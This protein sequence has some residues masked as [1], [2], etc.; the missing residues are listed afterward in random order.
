MLKL[1]AIALHI[2]IVGCS[3]APSRSP[4]SAQNSEGVRFYSGL[5]S[6]PGSPERKASGQMLQE[7]LDQTATSAS[8]LAEANSSADARRSY[9]ISKN[10]LQM[11]VD[12]LK[13]DTTCTSDQ[14]VRLY[15]GVG[16]Y[17]IVKQN[18]SWLATWSSWTYHSVVSGQPIPSEKNLSFS[19]DPFVDLT[20]KVSTQSLG[21]SRTKNLNWDRMVYAH[22]GTGSET[23]PLLST[24]LDWTVARRFAAP[25]LIVMDVCVERAMALFYMQA[26]GQATFS[27]AEIC[28]PLFILPEEVVAV[29]PVPNERLFFQLDQKWSKPPN[30]LTSGARRAFF[31]KDLPFDVEYLTQIS[32]RILSGMN[33]SQ[34]EFHAQFV[35]SEFNIFYENI[36]NRYEQPGQTVTDWR[37][38]ISE[39]IKQIKGSFAT[40]KYAFNKYINSDVFRLGEKPPS[41]FVFPNGVKLTSPQFTIAELKK[42]NSEEEKFESTFTKALLNTDPKFNIRM[43]GLAKYTNYREA[44]ESVLI[45]KRKLFSGYLKDCAD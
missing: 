1:I 43:D 45:F 23:S 2:L 12:Y 3:H 29:I 7:W 16:P 10:V 22:S 5:W 19:T 44:L 42:V 31:N 41:S 20:Y 4:A 9:I 17:G 14:K 37:A 40:C 24:S 33:P 39:K 34:A 13:A 36:L 30:A 32:T 27:E 25:N 18:S 11:S 28:L 15:R 38:M 26:A 8:V 35:K 6:S 21:A